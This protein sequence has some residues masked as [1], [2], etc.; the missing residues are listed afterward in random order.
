M[1][2]A[3]LS[4]GCMFLCGILASAALGTEHTELAEV[5][6]VACRTY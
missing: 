4:F 1:T 2:L 3:R 5:D 6:V